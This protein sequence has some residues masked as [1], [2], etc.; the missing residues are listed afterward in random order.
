MHWRADAL[1]AEFDSEPGITFLENPD[2]DAARRSHPSHAPMSTTV[3]T[4]HKTDGTDDDGRP[5][6]VVERHGSLP[7]ELLAPA[8]AALG[9][10][11]SLSPGAARRLSQRSYGDDLRV[12]G[13]HLG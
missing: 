13:G 1:K 12:G 2:E 4:F 3:L 9:Y 10:G 6:L 5:R 8:V 11:L 7:V